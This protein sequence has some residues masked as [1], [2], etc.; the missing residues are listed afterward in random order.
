MLCREVPDMRAITA[1]FALALSCGVSAAQPAGEMLRPALSGSELQQAVRSLRGGNDVVVR[2]RAIGA[3]ALAQL[4]QAAPPNPGSFDSLEVSDSLILGGLQ[5]ADTTVNI[6]LKLHEN[7]FTETAIFQRVNFKENV[8]ISGNTFRSVASFK[9]STFLEAA[10][11]STNTFAAF[12]TFE[13]ATFAREVIFYLD[14]FEGVADFSFVRFEGPASFERVEFTRDVE[15]AGAGVARSFQLNDSTIS[16]VAGFRDL[17]LGESAMFARTVF[18]KD[19]FFDSVRGG[20][21]SK[22]LFYATTF[23]GRT[24]FDGSVI[25]QISFSSRSEPGAAPGPLPS[26]PASAAALLLERRFYPPTSFQKVAV[27]RNVQCEHADFTEAEFQDQADFLGMRIGRWASFTGATFRDDVTFL[28][29]VFPDP[30]AEGEQSRRG[31]AFE[32]THFKGRVS[33]NRRQLFRDRAWWQ[34]VTGEDSKLVTTSATT[35]YALEEVFRAS[36]NL[37]A[38]NEAYYQRRLLAYADREQVDESALSNYLSW[39][40]WGY[41]VRPLRLIFWITVIFAVFTAVYWS[42]IASRGVQAIRDAIIFSAKTAWTF[43]YGYERARTPAFKAITLVQS[44]GTK[45]LALCLL[46]VLSNVSPFLNAVLGKLLP[47]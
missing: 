19:A 38:Q 20:Q 44:I 12:A 21:D 6:S 32:G 28:G 11:W 39:A 45:V 10:E 14:H 41:A 8:N 2:H 7:V 24:Y 30:P 15:F 4:I 9:D 25:D 31:L 22:L 35:W 13:H 23:N 5:L 36:G 18:S 1:V 26:T 34:R 42:Q 29:A 16:G 40:F 46:H 17:R 27:F 43:R 33:L 3:E 47:L 37:Y